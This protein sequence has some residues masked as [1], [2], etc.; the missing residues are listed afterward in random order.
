MSRHDTDWLS[1]L[2]GLVFTGLGLAY[3]VAVALHVH[4]PA[5]WTLSALLSALGVAGL[6]GTAQTRRRRRRNSA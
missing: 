1:L 4:I 3:L 2:C 5:I 6:I